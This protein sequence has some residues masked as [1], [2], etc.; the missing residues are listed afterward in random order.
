MELILARWCGCARQCRKTDANEL[1]FSVS[2]GVDTIIVHAKGAPPQMSEGIGVVVEGT[3]TKAG[4]FKVDQ[5]MVST[6]T[7]T[8]HPKTVLTL[9]VFTKRLKTY[10]LITWPPM[11]RLLYL[12]VSLA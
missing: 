6:Q 4:V 1:T 10:D 5:L 11:I 2:N 9:Q 3:M 12:P 7:N 8:R